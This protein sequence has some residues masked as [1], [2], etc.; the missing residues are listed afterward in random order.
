MS[1]C[2]GHTVKNIIAREGVDQ[3]FS[4]HKYIQSLVI[5]ILGSSLLG[6]WYAEYD[7]WIELILFLFIHNS[8]NKEIL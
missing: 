8:N 4:S 6:E 5:N 3:E 7:P 2:V 1:D